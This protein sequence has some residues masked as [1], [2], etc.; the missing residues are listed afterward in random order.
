MTAVSWGNGIYKVAAWLGVAGMFLFALHPAGSSLGYIG[1]AL[2]MLSLF[3]LLPVRWRALGRDPVVMAMGV[4]VAYLA[5]SGFMAYQRFGEAYAEPILDGLRAYLE[6]LLVALAFGWW[7]AGRSRNL[8]VLLVLAITGLLIR[9]LM[10]VDWQDPLGF[11][12]TARRPGFGMSV[13]HFALS[14]A[15]GLVGLMVFARRIV[16]SSKSLT[17]RLVITMGYAACVAVVVIAFG[18]SG[19]R[20]A[21]LAFALAAPF[22]LLYVTLNRTQPLGETRTRVTLLILICGVLAAGIWHQRDSITPRLINGWQ[23]ISATADL[24]VQEAAAQAG[25]FGKRFE[26]LASGIETFRERPV[27]GWGIGAG[28][29]L[30]QGEAD[31][32]LVEYH[33]HN[34]YIQFLVETGV[35][36]AALLALFL[37]LLGHSVYRAYR[38]RLFP[39][40]VVA[41]LVLSLAVAAV[42]AMGDGKLW[43]AK[44]RNPFIFLFGV[45]MAIHFVGMEARRLRHHRGFP[46]AEQP[47][48]A[49]VPGGGL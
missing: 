39:S 36:G 24:S 25:S 29:P 38:E 21:W 16:G 17:V 13:I 12:T 8:L 27:L 35:T 45:A 44:V 5:F 4:L 49:A 30:H 11:L 18:L 7:L 43:Q 3:L 9:I 31:I 34:L 23:T 41:W 22:I 42:W 19:T 48:P 28:E 1:S 40:D 20:T 32:D 46:A 2:L 10:H 33:L 47:N 37:T 6:L 26:M 14:A 15:L